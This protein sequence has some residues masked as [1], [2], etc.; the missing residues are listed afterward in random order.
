MFCEFRSK[1]LNLREERANAFKWFYCLFTFVILFY[2]TRFSFFICAWEIKLIIIFRV[3]LSSD[4]FSIVVDHLSGW[5]YL[6]RIQSNLK[7][8]FNK[9]YWW[10]SGKLCKKKKNQIQKY[11]Q[12]ISKLYRNNWF[13][14]I[15]TRLIWEHSTN[16]DCQIKIQM[17]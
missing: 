3:S 15:V 1:H 14:D 10:I 9:P 16:F 4:Y 13:F 8:N 2:R 11:K 6:F 7:I 12:L 5:K 17:L